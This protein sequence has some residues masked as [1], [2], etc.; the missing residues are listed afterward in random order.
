MGFAGRQRRIIDRQAV[1][2]H[3]QLE[4]QQ[5]VLGDAAQFEPLFG[6][7]VEG[8]GVAVILD[9]DRVL[10]LAEQQVEIVG[11][12]LYRDVL[13]RF[14]VRAFGQFVLLGG[15]LLVPFELIVGEERL[16][17]GERDRLRIVGFRIL[18]RELV[19]PVE[20]RVEPQRTARQRDILLDRQSERV[21]EIVVLH[22]AH[23]P[24]VVIL[25]QPQRAI[26]TQH[27]A[28]QVQRR[29][30]AGAVGAVGP[31]G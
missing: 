24:R 28:R 26:E 15:D 30:P 31:V 19:E 22:V 11:H 7:G 12:R 8:F 23:L 20:R 21:L 6:D 14:D 2:E 29:Q 27:F 9:G 16:G 25:Q 5:L 17:V 1:V 4:L 18:R 3:P 10:G 13:H